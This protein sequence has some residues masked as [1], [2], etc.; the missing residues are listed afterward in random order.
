MS[1]W[2][3]GDVREVEE[4]TASSLFVGNA[5]TLARHFL[6]SRT[7]VSKASSNREEEMGHEEV[8]KIK[9]S[10]DKIKV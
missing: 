7:A 1:G 5:V 10:R 6:S 9:T 4:E 2:V 8:K 3:E